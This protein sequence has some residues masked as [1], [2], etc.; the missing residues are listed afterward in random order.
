MSPTPKTAR[1][2]ALTA[3]GDG[4]RASRHLA[5]LPMRSANP[6]PPAPNT[7]TPNTSTDWISV[8]EVFYGV[9]VV[10]RLIKIYSGILKN[11][12][13]GFVGKVKGV[14]QLLTILQFAR[15]GEWL[16]LISINSEFSNFSFLKAHKVG[17]HSGSSGFFNN[18]SA[19]KIP[20]SIFKLC[21]SSRLP[22]FRTSDWINLLLAVFCMAK[23]SRKCPT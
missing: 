8:L 9:A 13:I 15:I 4:W 21:T 17:Q 16:H 10:H 2:L 23:I 7:I 12:R 19:N 1:T 11:I 18:K 3:A 22:S 14:R 6:S 20:F 5:F